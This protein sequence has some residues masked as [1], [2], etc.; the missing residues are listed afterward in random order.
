MTKS[1]CDSLLVVPDSELQVP[2]DDT[3]LLVVA[4]GVASELEN[5]SSKVLENSREVYWRRIVASA[6]ARKSAK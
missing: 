3:L 5:L 4:R 6:E 2:W 1:L